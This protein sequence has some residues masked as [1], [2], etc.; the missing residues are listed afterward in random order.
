[1][2][3]DSA[4][5]VWLVRGDGH[6]R[7]LRESASH[8]DARCIA[9]HRR[10]CYAGGPV[11]ARQRWIRRIVAGWL[12]VHLSSLVSVPLVLCA[13]TTSLGTSA[14]CTCSHEDGTM[15]PMHHTV[16]PSKSKSTSCSCRSS[17]DP[18][19]AIAA[20]LVGPAAVL[21]ATPVPFTLLRRGSGIGASTAPIHD[22]YV[23]PIAPPP[24]A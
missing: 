15:C 20:S 5:G 17:A 8:Q 23:V 24:R 1:M 2:P 6:A 9:D 7:V 4:L 18:M 13:T 14:E 16:K 12:L 19:S 22:A 11:Q 21:T 3:R 10:L